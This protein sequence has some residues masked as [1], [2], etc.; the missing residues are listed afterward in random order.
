MLCIYKETY[1]GKAD[2]DVDVSY[3]GKTDVER[4]TVTVNGKD[5]DKVCG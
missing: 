4:T 5:N 2:V 1:K 3:K